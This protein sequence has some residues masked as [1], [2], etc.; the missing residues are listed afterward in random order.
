MDQVYKLYDRQASPKICIKDYF[1]QYSELIKSLMSHEVGKQGE[2]KIVQ[3]M[4]TD[5]SQTRILLI[6]HYC[7][8]LILR[9][10]INNTVFSSGNKYILY[11]GV[12]L[13]A[14]II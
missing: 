14:S 5:L 3:L 10:V 6:K 7:R 9:C 8:Y 11:V 13:T 2:E 4:G 12:N 1:Q